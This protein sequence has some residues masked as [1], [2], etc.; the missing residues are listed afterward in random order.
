MHPPRPGALDLRFQSVSHA[1]YSLFAALVGQAR[2]DDVCYVRLSSCL[3]CV[4]GREKMGIASCWSVRNG[5]RW[6][7]SAGVS[8]VRAL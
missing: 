7:R 6:A 1:P 4:S 8:F 5:E 2:G 3:P